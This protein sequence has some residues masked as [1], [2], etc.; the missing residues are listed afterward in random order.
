MRKKHSKPISNR[1]QNSTFWVLIIIRPKL[2]SQFIHE[3]PELNSSLQI[4][5]HKKRRAKSEG[6]RSKKH[7]KKGHN[8]NFA[9]LGKFRKLQNFATYEISQVGKFASCLPLFMPLLPLFILDFILPVFSFC[10]LFGFFLF[11]PL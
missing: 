10:S 1:A 4:R 2:S 9:G 6:K 5:S 7:K 11:Y 8:K 3:E